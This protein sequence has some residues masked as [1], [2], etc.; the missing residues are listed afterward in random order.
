MKTTTAIDVVNVT[1]T[2]GLTPALRGIDVS[3]AAGE[4]AAVMGPS[5]SGK[6]TLLH[7][8][9]GILL[10]GSGEV[11]TA[12][13]NLGVL[14]EKARSALR[15]SSFGFVF[16]FGQ[17][18]PELTAIANVAVPLLFQGVARAA[19]EQQARECLGRLNLDDAVDKR[20]PQ[21][22][23]GQAQRVAIAR[24]LVTK[25]AILFADEPTGAL[26]TLSAENVMNL[27]LSQAQESGTTVVIVTH[28]PRTA[29]YCDRA[30][31]VRDGRL[32]AMENERAS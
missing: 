22:S 31:I 19:A 30:I 24:A 17:L 18:L 15:L 29:A 25:P 13:H 26:D 8:M 9:A 3:I 6:S 20:P 27:M 1:K 16:Q 28:D 5:G 32:G 4:V 7:C 14:S 11:T 2:F 21:L 10:P 12:G 23:G